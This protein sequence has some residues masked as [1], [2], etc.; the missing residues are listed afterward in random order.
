MACPYSMSGGMYSGMTILAMTARGQDG[1]ATTIG[2]GI[3]RRRVV[4]PFDAVA[5][6]LPGKMAA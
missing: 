4:V 2:N 6:S 3:G 1:R 5:A